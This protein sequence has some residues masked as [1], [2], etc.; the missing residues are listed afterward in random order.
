MTK[1]YQQRVQRAIIGII[2]QEDSRQFDNC[3]EM[4]DGTAVVVAIWRE[5]LKKQTIDDCM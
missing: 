2:A 3:F 1:A 4:W 5:A